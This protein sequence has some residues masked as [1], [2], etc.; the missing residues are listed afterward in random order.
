MTAKLLCT[1][2]LQAKPVVVLQISEACLV[3]GKVT[4]EACG[5]ARP[6]QHIGASV[7]VVGQLLAVHRERLVGQ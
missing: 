3:L 1:N 4:V 2:L 5:V 6:D 7:V